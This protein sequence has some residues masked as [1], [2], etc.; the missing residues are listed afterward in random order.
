MIEL[1]DEV[2]DTENDCDGWIIKRKKFDVPSFGNACLYVTHVIEFTKNPN[3]WNIKQAKISAVVQKKGDQTNTLHFQFYDYAKHRRP[4]NRSGEFLYVPCKDWMKKK[5]GI[6]VTGYGLTGHGLLHRRIRK[7]SNGR[8]ENAI[9]SHYNNVDDIYTVTY[10]N[11][12]T[13]LLEL[14][15]IEVYLRP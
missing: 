3:P 6:K 1:Q 2:T 12:E 5:S 14:D 4:P 10:S 8:W 13:E 9:V 11:S 7:D 15:E